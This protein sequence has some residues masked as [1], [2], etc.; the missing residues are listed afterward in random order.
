MLN[1]RL[2]FFLLIL[3]AF[4][5]AAADKALVFAFD[6]NVMPC[7][8][9]VVESSGLFT[10]PISFCRDASTLFAFSLSGKKNLF[11]GPSGHDY[12]AGEFIFAFLQDER[13]AEDFTLFGDY[14]GSLPPPTFNPESLLFLSET[15]GFFEFSS[16][17]KS[18]CFKEA[19]EESENPEI[20]LLRNLMLYL[21][22]EEW[23]DF[24]SASKYSLSIFS[25]IPGDEEALKM[26]LM[27]LMNNAEFAAANSIMDSFY[28]KRDK[29]EL[30][31]S[32]KANLFA[33]WG[34][35]DAAEKY[36]EEGRTLY[37][38]SKTL[39]MDAINLY[40]VTDTVKMAELLDFY[41]MR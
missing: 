28:S 40:S 30:F 2:T 38:E 39:L 33:I 4:V 14:S 24:K 1:T 15:M 32:L 25:R 21:H 34:K 7:G 23:N 29:G 37:P 36:V 10:L 20:S 11:F 22:A 8:D 31:Y 12:A 9:T 16:V 13:Q 41:E 17:L 26:R 35:F 27:S 18:Y 5:H 6:S 19:P 3:T